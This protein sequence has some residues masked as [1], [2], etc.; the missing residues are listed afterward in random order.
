MYV[1]CMRNKL[2]T[3]PGNPG[4]PMAAGVSTLIGLD[5]LGL[6][7]GLNNHTV[8]AFMPLLHRPIWYPFSIGQIG[9]TAAVDKVCTWQNVLGF[10]MRTVVNSTHTVT[11]NVSDMRQ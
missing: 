5:T 9:S 11:V 6:H 3:L 1:H 10:L 4:N 8:R 7:S 2:K